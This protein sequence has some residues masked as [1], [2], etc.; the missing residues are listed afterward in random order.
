[1]SLYGSIKIKPW[2][3]ELRHKKDLRTR[4]LYVYR[5]KKDDKPGAKSTEESLFDRDGWSLIGR[6][7]GITVSKK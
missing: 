7:V 6:L 5:S 1:M 4:G 3:Q 2:E